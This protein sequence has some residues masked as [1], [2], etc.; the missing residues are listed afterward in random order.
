MDNAHW[1]GIFLINYFFQL[2][3]FS[4]KI[5]IEFEEEKVNYTGGLQHE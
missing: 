4:K 2:L 5:K 1:Q 3:S